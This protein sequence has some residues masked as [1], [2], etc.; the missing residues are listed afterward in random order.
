[1]VSIFLLGR[2]LP[3][4]KL[5]NVRQSMNRQGRRAEPDR[6][7]SSGVL[8]FATLLKMNWKTDWTIGH[9]AM[10]SDSS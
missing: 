2:E 1:M 6:S 7:S 4:P 9:T 8:W 3:S 10:S 5:K